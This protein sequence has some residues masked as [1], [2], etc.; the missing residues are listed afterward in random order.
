MY[1]LEISRLVFLLFF[2]R[3]LIFSATLAGFVRACVCVC[4][5]CVVCG[6]GLG[7]VSRKA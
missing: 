7:L 6:V 4:V 2:C 5:L 3:A 1:G